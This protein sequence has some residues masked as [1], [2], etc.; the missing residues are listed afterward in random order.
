MLQKTGKSLGWQLD[1]G[2]H[3]KYRWGELEQHFYAWDEL[4]PGDLQRR[5]HLKMLLRKSL[6]LRTAV[7]LMWMLKF[8]IWVVITLMWREN[9]SSSR[10]NLG[11]G[12]LCSSETSLLTGPDR[13]IG[14]LIGQ[15]FP[16]GPSG[17]LGEKTSREH[18]LQHWKPS[19]HGDYL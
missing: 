2:K 12:Q 14:S 10:R 13:L 19:L 7:A 9:R 4:Q 16:D 11:C 17:S 15:S 5:S 6:V 8:R 18:V 3:S 1:K